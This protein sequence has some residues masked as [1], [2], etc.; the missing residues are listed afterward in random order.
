MELSKFCCIDTQ[1]ASSLDLLGY[2]KTRFELISCA[3]I[4]EERHERGM[5]LGH[6][7]GDRFCVTEL[8]VRLL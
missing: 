3:L 7:L 1:L 6:I 2:L 5:V 8:L 4:G